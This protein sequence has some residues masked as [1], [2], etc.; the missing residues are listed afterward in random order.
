RDF[1]VGR[2]PDFYRTELFVRLPDGGRRRLPPPDDAILQQHF[3]G[4]LVFSL[5]SD[6]MLPDGRKLAAGGLYSFDFQQ[7]LKGGEVTAIEALF[8]PSAK[9]AVLS[10]ARTKGRLYVSLIDNVR[11]RVIA[12]DHDEGR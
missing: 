7:W 3:H 8:E 5:R 6:W 11:G 1:I 9:A 4:Q 10:T 2:G 12:F